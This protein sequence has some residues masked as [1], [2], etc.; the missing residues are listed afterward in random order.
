MPIDPA[1]LVRSLVPLTDLDPVADLA[2]TLNLVVVAAKQLFEVDA[3]GSRWGFRSVR[4]AKLLASVAG[5]IGM[6]VP[7]VPVAELANPV[8]RPGTRWP[9][10]RS[11]PTAPRCRRVGFSRSLSTAA[12]GSVR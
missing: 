11:G 10:C 6:G 8:N 1:T 3:A 9:W 7:L 2:S 5:S 12:T 4:V